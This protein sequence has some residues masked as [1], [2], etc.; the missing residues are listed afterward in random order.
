MKVSWLILVLALGAVGSLPGQTFT[1]TS[2]AALFASANAAAASGRHADAAA[3]LEK[4][5]A[6]GVVT[7]AVYYNLANACAQS[8][9]PGD[10]VLNYERALW[11]DPHDADARANL[12]LCRRK[13]GLFAESPEW[14]EI[15]PGWMSLDAWSWMASAAT[16]LWVA[17]MILGWFKAGTGRS[18]GLRFA[19]AVCLLAAVMAAAA[20]AVRSRD[21]D[22]AVVTAAEAP[23]RVSPTALSP[24]GFQLAA[25]TVVRVLKDH[26]GFHYVATGDGK[27]GWMA[28]SEARLVVPR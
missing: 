17:A 6:R 25:G 22:R 16:A 8:G 2:E 11:L 26:P 9:R 18:W 4:L 23:L 3:D 14:W 10:A 7:P 5:I 15:V 12:A 28:D 20:A 1:S 24:A 13:A 27:T 21:L 19:A